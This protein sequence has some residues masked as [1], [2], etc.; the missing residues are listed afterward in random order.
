MDWGTILPATLTVVLVVTA[1][2]LGL[3][4][5]TVRTL[6][7]SN[8]DLRNRRDDLEKENLGLET[9]VSKLA[10]ENDVLKSIVTG[11]VHWAALN[12]QLE[13]H[14]KQAVDYWDRTGHLLRKIIE[15]LED[16]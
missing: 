10:A 8:Q 16:H 13:E 11:E 12:D 4:Q 15:V 7:D 1:G 14:H 3:Q 2:L 6:R 9:R 5:G